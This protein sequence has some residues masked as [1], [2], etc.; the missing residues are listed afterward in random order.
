MSGEVW[1]PYV[2]AWASTRSVLTID[3]TPSNL[4]SRAITLDKLTDNVAAVWEYL[5]V[6]ASVVVG[7]SMGGM[8]TQLLALTRPTRV[9]SCVLISTVGGFNQ[10]GAAT[11]RERARLVQYMDSAEATEDA[12]VRWFGSAVVDSEA[13]FVR[14]ARR[15][16]LGTPKST[17]ARTWEAIAEFDL[18]ERLAEIR[19]RCLVIAGDRDTSTSV[20]ETQQFARSLPDARL[21]L[22]VGAGH[23]AILESAGE[24]RATIDTH[25][26][27]LVGGD[28]DRGAKVM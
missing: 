7:C 24:V 21:E 3:L 16:L 23:M 9:T 27:W 13:A 28:D 22:L 4:E 25:T 6:S 14:R 19:Q 17:Q 10:K 1:A 18:R 15:L 26:P 8:I 12:L 20:R 11:L 5:G 2:E